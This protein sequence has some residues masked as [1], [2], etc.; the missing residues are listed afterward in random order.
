M[1]KI[2]Y[3]LALV[4]FGL[5]SNGQTL[6]YYN[7]TNTPLSYSN[8]YDVEPFDTCVYFIDRTD[9]VYT[10][11]YYG[12]TKT[13]LPT[14]GVSNHVPHAIHLFTGNDNK[15]Y[16]ISDS[17][18]FKKTSTSWQY[19]MPS[20][21]LISP[22]YYNTYNLNKPNLCIDTNSVFWIPPNYLDSNHLWKYANN[23]WTSIN[24]PTWANSSFD[25]KIVTDDSLYIYWICNNGIAKYDGNSFTQLHANCK[26]KNLFI[27]KQS[28]ELW[29]F[30]SSMNSINYDTNIRTLACKIT[31]NSLDTFSI[32]WNSIYNQNADYAIHNNKMQIITCDLYFTWDYSYFESSPSITTNTTNLGTIFMADSMLFKTRVDNYGNIW[33]TSAFGYSRSIFG[34]RLDNNKIKGSVFHDQNWNG[35]QDAGEPPLSNVIVKAHP[36]GDSASTLA[37]GS[38]VIHL[39]QPSGTYTLNPVL[40]SPWIVT[41]QPAAYSVSQSTYGQIDSGFV[42]GIASQPNVSVSLIGAPNMFRTGSKGVYNLYIQNYSS[43]PMDTIYLELQHHDS[44]TFDTSNYTPHL[45]LNNKI[46]WKIPN[47][48]VYEKKHIGA[49][50]KVSNYL[51]LGT[52]LTTHGIAAAFS[53]LGM[54][55]DT[56]IL[57]H[58][59]YASLDP[60]NK[61][62]YYGFNTECLNPGDTIHYT[63]N[64]Q[65]CGN[66]TAFLVVIR[67][68]LSPD[69]DLNTL[70]II[71]SSHDF[72]WQIN[73]NEL[74]FTYQNIVLPDSGTNY[75]ESMGF[76]NYSIAVGNYNPATTGIIENTAHIF[77]DQN[78]DVITNTSEVP[79]CNTIGLNELNNNSSIWL[80]PNPANSMIFLKTSTNF[81]H[82][83][84]KVMNAQGQIILQG[85]FDNSLSECSI[86][87]SSL[88]AGV[89]F[90]MLD[91]NSKLRFIKQ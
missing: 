10:Y 69:L 21:D 8:I 50:F 84:Y 58:I 9:T 74:V 63:V 53:P 15:L 85:K 81:T 30:I 16:V 49:M 14:T 43:I 7:P 3:T 20:V 11:D 62:E 57:N 45:V 64:F 37:D 89:Y 40:A 32:N 28:Q 22:L 54:A 36:N 66:D 76:V 19:V 56:V 35:I 77:F 2:I 46:L 33:Y 61:L 59:V 88:S 26:F 18:V 70:K 47:F 12:W 42:F 13:N 41:S 51:T 73:G 65:N 25:S 4:I 48:N 91:D 79:L 31:N 75:F 34:F 6:V 24:I 23:N 29:G 1:K 38:Y 27:D 72:S 67:D 80:E 5:F 90:L 44:L 82:K 78:P 39:P 55:E 83:V 60:N 17:A 68:T 71:S 86:D 52:Q 87:I